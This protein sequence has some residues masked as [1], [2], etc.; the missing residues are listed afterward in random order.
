M[1]VSGWKLLYFL[2]FAALYFISL[3]LLSW[4]QITREDQDPVETYLSII[5]GAGQIG[6]GLGTI[7]ITIEGSYIMLGSYLKEKWTKEARDE[8]I[9]EGI[10]EG[11]IE[12]RRQAL[13]EMESWARRKAEAEARGE[14]FDEP[15]PTIEPNG[16]R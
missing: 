5:L 7:V 12:G 11:I 8:G 16:R 10:A 3:G 9:A 13:E 2:S 6:V 15:P 1:K 4:H 14:Q